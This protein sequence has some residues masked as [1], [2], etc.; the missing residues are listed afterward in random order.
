MNK[1][2]V[3]RLNLI[4]ENNREDIFLKE[5]LNKTKVIQNNDGMPYDVYIQKQSYVKCRTRKYIN[6]N[7]K[8]IMKKREFFISKHYLRMKELE[9]TYG[10]SGK[11][12]LYKIYDIKFL[13]K[14]DLEDYLST[15]TK[16]KIHQI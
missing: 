12:I 6:K 11:I 9:Y 10:A 14:K 7:T 15:F 1:K 3:R 4:T 5:R 13:D 8:S 2:R 16:L